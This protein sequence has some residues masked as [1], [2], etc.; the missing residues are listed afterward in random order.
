M[1]LI[2]P[3]QHSAKRGAE[4]TRSMKTVRERP[5][6]PAMSWSALLPLVVAAN[7]VVAMVAWHIVDSVAR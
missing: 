3:R 2:G 6:L 7:V 4:G 5:I 1:S